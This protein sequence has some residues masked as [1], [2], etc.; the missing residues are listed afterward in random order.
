MSRIVILVIAVAL[1]GCVSLSSVA[2]TQ[3]PKE[4]ENM[5]FASNSELL[6]LGIAFDNDFVNVVTDDLRKQCPDGKVQGILTKYEHTS[7]VFVTERRV[8][9][10]GYCVQKI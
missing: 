9:A 8:V 5:V 2:L 10:E 7:Y 1:S 6:F 3:I 4:R